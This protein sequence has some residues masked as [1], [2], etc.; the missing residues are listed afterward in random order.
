MSSDNK[1]KGIEAL[2]EASK[3]L[4]QK[5]IVKNNPITKTTDQEKVAVE[6]KLETIRSDERCTNL[7]L[8]SS[9]R[10][11]PGNFTCVRIKRQ[12]ISNHPNIERESPEYGNFVFSLEDDAKNK[13][14]ANEDYQLININGDAL[15]TLHQIDHLSYSI[16]R[17]SSYP[18]QVG[19]TFYSRLSRP[20][21][22]S[23]PRQVS[24][25]LYSGPPLPCE[26]DTI[27]CEINWA[28]SLG[29]NVLM[30][31]C[32]QPD[33]LDIV[34]TIISSEANP[35]AMD[36]LHQGP[37]HYA[38]ASGN[39]EVIQWLVSHVGLPV[40]IRGRSLNWTPLLAAVMNNQRESIDLLCA[41]KHA[42]NKRKPISNDDNKESI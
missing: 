16:V 11:D 36:I 30:L 35:Y 20:R 22:S 32:S 40:D 7:Q 38:A 27:E 3:V 5:R 2:L 33:N 23:C 18:H 1:F 42:R 9:V 10:A 6:E 26:D 34:Q 21:R 41:L 39:L 14:L 31:A 12:R 24:G 13:R 37:L 19:G 15:A 17:R 25:T 28:D 29:V 4:E 8:S